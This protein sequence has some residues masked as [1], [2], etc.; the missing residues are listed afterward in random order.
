MNPIANTIQITFNPFRYNRLMS[1]SIPKSLANCIQL[2]EFNIEGN[3]VSAL[4]DGLLSSLGNLCYITLSRNQFSAFPAGGPAQFIH[5]QSLNMEHNQ[6]DRIPYG[7]FSRAKHLSK[8]NMKENQLTSLP[9][10]N[11]LQI[12]SYL[13]V[14]I[15]QKVKS[16]LT[17]NFL[18]KTNLILAPF[19]QFSNFVMFLCV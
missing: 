3:S 8:L 9:I 17:Q 2:A 7:I 5:V 1:G 6:C 12:L 4:P 19:D 13:Q 11:Y 14:S 16:D 10:G 15:F 18:N